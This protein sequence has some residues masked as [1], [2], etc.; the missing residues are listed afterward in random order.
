MRP[1][2]FRLRR[3]VCAS[4]RSLS[5]R[6]IR[7]SESSMI[8]QGEGLDGGRR[9]AVRIRDRRPLR[10]TVH[11]DCRGGPTAGVAVST[12]ASFAPSNECGLGFGSCTPYRNN[13]VSCDQSR[14][15][16]QLALLAQ[17]PSIV[18]GQSAD[19]RLVQTCCSS[20]TA[21]PWSS[22]RRGNAVHRKPGSFSAGSLPHR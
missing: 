14:A 11:D 9:E 3:N 6:S 8:R 15:R 19:A 7:G 5:R 18:S 4:S 1:S 20:S 22:F 17:S 21:S 10:R 13:R 2:C 12:V 16:W